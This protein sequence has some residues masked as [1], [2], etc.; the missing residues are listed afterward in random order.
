MGESIV[1]AERLDVWR[2]APAPRSVVEGGV[3]QSVRVG[4][5]VDR[6]D[7]SCLF[8]TLLLLLLLLFFFFLDL[9]VQT[10]EGIRGS[11][12]AIQMTV[13]LE[14]PGGFLPRILNHSEVH[15]FLKKLCHL[16][17]SHRIELLRLLKIL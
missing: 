3:V 8:F 4:V 16:V 10:V 5:A 14:F 6:G 2:L 13:P 9:I 17:L 15:E 1:L 12:K 11:D 7:R